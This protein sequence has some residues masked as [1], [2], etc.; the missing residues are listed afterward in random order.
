MPPLQESEECCL[1]HDTRKLIRCLVRGAALVEVVDDVNEHF[2]WLLVG[3]GIF[4]KVMVA[5]HRFVL[6]LHSCVVGGAGV[7]VFTSGRHIAGTQDENA[8]VR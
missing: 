2:A 6:F 3:G 4:K 8:I 7:S 5:S 1:R